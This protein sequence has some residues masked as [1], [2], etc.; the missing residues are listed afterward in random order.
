MSQFAWQRPDPLGAAEDWA[1]RR[2][3]RIAAFA[4]ATQVGGRRQ[5]HAEYPSL[6]QARAAARELGCVVFGKRAI[7]VA[8]SPEGW[9]FEIERIDFE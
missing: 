1:K 5:V 9:A 8:L 6:A 7:I 4:L 2:H 3:T